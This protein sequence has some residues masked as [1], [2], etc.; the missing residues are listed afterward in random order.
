MCTVLQTIL[1][2]ASIS[3]YFMDTHWYMCSMCCMDCC[4]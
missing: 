1:K 3:F 2:L 4:S